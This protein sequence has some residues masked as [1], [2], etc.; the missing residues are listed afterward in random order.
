MMKKTERGTGE[1]GALRAGPFVAALQVVLRSLL[2]YRTYEHEA[3]EKAIA[4]IR[5]GLSLARP[6]S[7]LNFDHG[8]V[9]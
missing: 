4:K 6:M 1:S 7:H 8:V 3:L 5:C 9:P 2:R